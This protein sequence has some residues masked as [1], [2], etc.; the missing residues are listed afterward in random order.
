MCSFSLSPPPYATAQVAELKAELKKRDLL[1][2]GKKDEL[3]ARLL[4]H[5]STKAPPQGLGEMDVSLISNGDG[6]DASFESKGSV[7][8]TASSASSASSKSAASAASSVSDMS[9]VSAV[10]SGGTPYAKK[11]KKATIYLQDDV[12]SSMEVEEEV[13]EKQKEVSDLQS[14]LS[15]MRKATTTTAAAKP[16]PYFK[17]V[18]AV[19]PAAPAAPAAGPAS[20]RAAMLAAWRTKNPTSSSN[21]SPV[22]KKE[23]FAVP[24]SPGIKRSRSDE[25]E[26]LGGASKKIRAE[27]R[28]KG[29]LGGGPAGGKLDQ[30]KMANITNTLDSVNNMVM[31]L[32]KGGGLGPM[33]AAKSATALGRPAVSTKARPAPKWN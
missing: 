14:R 19:K 7:E 20:D 28:R 10:S 8:S 23:P 22:R 31:S 21:S 24:K 16:A 11:V 26:G 17:T 33:A 29:G 30:A 3:A 9:A 32:P 15:A 1:V 5:E 18:K 6:A 27:M 13:K 4:A 25:G 12:E 2:G